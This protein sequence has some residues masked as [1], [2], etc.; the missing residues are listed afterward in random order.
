MERCS[1]VG[2]HPPDIHLPPVERGQASTPAAL[3]HSA[4]VDT[5]A[6]RSHV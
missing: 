3:N 1:C 4:Q 2:A 6:R 5:L